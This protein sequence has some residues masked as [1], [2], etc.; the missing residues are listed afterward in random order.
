MGYAP[1][2]MKGFSG[3][4]NSPA[5]QAGKVVKNIG[6]RF[7]GGPVG[8]VLN[9]YDIAKTFPGAVEAT[10][11]SLKKEAKGRAKGKATDLFRGSKI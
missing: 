4:G 7:L 10:K 3:F 9:A 11:E 6:K 2:K 1:F 5:K 8:V